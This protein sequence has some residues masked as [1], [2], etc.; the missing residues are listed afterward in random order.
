MMSFIRRVCRSARLAVLLLDRPAEQRLD[1]RQAARCRQPLVQ[2]A[3]LL[4]LDLLTDR[5]AQAKAALPAPALLLLEALLRTGQLLG[6]VPFQV[7]KRQQHQ[8]YPALYAA[9]VPQPITPQ[10]QGRFQLLK[11]EFDLP[12]QIVPFDQRGDLK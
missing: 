1:L 10:A 4:V 11:E 8:A 5:L 7:S 9:E 6:A 2:G 12:A 3:Q